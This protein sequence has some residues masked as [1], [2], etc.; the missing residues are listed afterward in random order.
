M[1]HKTPVEERCQLKP[2]GA[3]SAETPRGPRLRYRRGGSNT[4]SSPVE[5]TFCD[6]VTG[7]G[8][9]APIGFIGP[10]NS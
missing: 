7:R 4:S 1:S 2:T 8:G 6:R 5:A 9:P 10:P 3:S